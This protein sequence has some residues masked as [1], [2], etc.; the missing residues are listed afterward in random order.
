MKNIV[1]NEIKNKGNKRFFNKERLKKEEQE[2]K[3]KNSNNFNVEKKK[4]FKY[5]SA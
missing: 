3:R 2:K 5:P 1:L 4:K